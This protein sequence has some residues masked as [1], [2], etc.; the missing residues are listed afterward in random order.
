MKEH[1][2]WREICFQP[3]TFVVPHLWAIFKTSSTLYLN[4]I[5]IK[6]LMTS[7]SLFLQCWILIISNYEWY[8][9]LSL[10]YHIFSITHIK[11]GLLDGFKQITLF[12]IVLIIFLLPISTKN[13]SYKN[14]LSNS[15]FIHLPWAL[16]TS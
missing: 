4:I 11:Y 8:Y 1:K 3:I 12:F 5:A 15:T 16:F 6:A 10:C 14:N 2:F 9:W 7:I 13:E